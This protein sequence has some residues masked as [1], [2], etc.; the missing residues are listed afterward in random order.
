[1]KFDINNLLT[2]RT[3][4]TAEIDAD[5]DT[6]H[7]VKIGLAVKWAVKTG[8][9]LYHAGFAGADLSHANLSGANLA[10]ADLSYANFAG[11]DLTR[12]YLADVDLAGAKN[13]TARQLASTFEIPPEDIPVVPAID[14]AI[15]VA[16][17]AGG[18]L[19]MDDWHGGEGWCGTTHCRA[20]WAVHLAGPPGNALEDEVGPQMAGM[21]I[22][23]ASR[24][25]E[26]VPDFFAHHR[27]AW[28]DIQECA[29]EQR[30]EAGA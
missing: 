22:Y 21:L 3:Q 25:G 13:L 11:A 8:V 19:D 9:N 28:M 10:G 14:A 7:A 27:V 26:A 12:A 6:P 24:P 15:E 4:F 17:K 23:Q 30:A 18:T 5:E 29:A 2:G 20:G 16:V 1:M